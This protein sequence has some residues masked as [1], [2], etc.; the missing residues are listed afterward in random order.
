MPKEEFSEDE[1]KAHHTEVENYRL[2]A[3][4]LYEKN[5]DE[6]KDLV[7]IKADGSVKVSHH[8]VLSDLYEKYKEKFVKKQCNA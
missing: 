5:P 8:P 3:I 1:T 7:K 4:S 6:F 2:R